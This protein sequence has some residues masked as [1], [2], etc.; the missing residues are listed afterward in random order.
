LCPAA[1]RNINLEPLGREGR[2]V[3][4]TSQT[5]RLEGTKTSQ[6]MATADRAGLGVGQ[7]ATTELKMD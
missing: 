3:I 5:R 7:T 4:A 1:K 2:E 6:S